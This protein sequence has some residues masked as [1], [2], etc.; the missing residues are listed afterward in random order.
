MYYPC[1]IIKRTS[2]FR[3]ND[4]VDAT[5]TPDSEGM[6]LLQMDSKI[7]FKN[8]EIIYHDATIKSRGK[9]YGKKV[10]WIHNI[11][12]F[13]NICHYNIACELTRSK[14]LKLLMLK[15]IAC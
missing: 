8:L 14:R 5:I 1:R 9:N 15:T 6:V 7:P 11:L 4:Q 2:G 13:Y 10:R 3:I 12:L